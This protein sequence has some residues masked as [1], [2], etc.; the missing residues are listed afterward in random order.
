MPTSTFRTSSSVRTIRPSLIYFIIAVA[1][2][3]FWFLMAVPFAS[4][5]E[6]YTWLAS[7]H[8]GS[9][10]EGLGLIGKT[11]RPLGQ[12][13]A[14]LGFALLDPSIFPTSIP[15][16]AILQG[17]V[18]AMFLLGWRIMYSAVPQPRSF[19]IVAL[20]AGAVFF[21]GYIHLFHIYG[22]FYVP[23]MLILATMVRSYLLPGFA[24][25]E[26][27]L[28]STAIAMVLWHPFATVLFLG[29][30]FGRY[31]DTF[32]AYDRR[33]HV[34]AWI[35][36]VAG[37][38]AIVGMVIASPNLGKS[39]SYNPLAAFI[40]SYRT[41]EINVFA[42]L[43]ALI[44][45]YVALLSIG[46]PP[47]LRLVLS[48]VTAILGLGFFLADIPLLL[49]WI[50]VALGK[51]LHRRSWGLLVPLVVAT[52]LPYGG[53]I[54]G[55]IYGLF[56]IIL[57]VVVTPLGWTATETRLQSV[58]KR[59]AIALILG[60]L[61][62]VTAIRAGF[63]VP[64]VSTVARP[65]LAERERTFQLERALAWL[66]TSKYCAHDLA[67]VEAA[68]SPIDSVESAITRRH[69]PPS[70]VEDVAVFWEAALRCEANASTGRVKGTATITFGGPELSNATRV[71]DLPG[72]NAGPTTVWVR[73]R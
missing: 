10:L 30:Y 61:A 62:L 19:A 12:I 55:P 7:V 58:G 72:P 73:S 5:R 57:A 15:R 46:L 54:G 39:W 69:R 56:P 29:F 18:Y 71:L 14:W 27:F 67:F 28:V 65:L 32:R 21:S 60:L 50:L 36:L 31:L 48:V 8:H 52:L 16:Q 24:R 9:F 2:F 6:A 43:V 68:G 13:P 59:Y 42:S 53:R 35:V 44:L 37:L 47:R 4:H 25:R 33:Q 1:G 26:A 66:S 70:A 11:W 23:I 64:I 49:L 34:K 38:V 40:I 17:I 41:N 20:A 63:S 51:L 22:L 45:A 3:S